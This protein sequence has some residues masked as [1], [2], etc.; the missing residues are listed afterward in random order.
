MDEWMRTL[1]RTVKESLMN[2]AEVKIKLLIIKGKC[3]DKDEYIK[4]SHPNGKGGKYVEK[5]KIVEP[6]E[7]V[8]PDEI[9]NEDC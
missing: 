1:L 9:C 6:N 5:L 7:F 4:K 2:L 8:D 3:V